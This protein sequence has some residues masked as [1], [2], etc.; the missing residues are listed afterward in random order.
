MPKKEEIKNWWDKV[1]ADCSRPQHRKKHNASKVS[2]AE[3]I[4][5]TSPRAML[6]IHDGFL[7]LT[8]STSTTLDGSQAFDVVD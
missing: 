7:Q 5:E 1:D 8:K 6:K 4:P 3:L 2:A